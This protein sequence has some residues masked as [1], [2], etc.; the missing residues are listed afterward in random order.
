MEADHGGVA[1]TCI[2]TSLHRAHINDQAEHCQPRTVTG[3]NNDV[4]IAC[5]ARAPKVF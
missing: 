3:A 2:C 4:S 1:S 5:N